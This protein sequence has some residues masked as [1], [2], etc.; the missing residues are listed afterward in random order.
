MVAIAAMIISHPKTIGLPIGMEISFSTYFLFAALL[1]AWCVVHSLL[2]SAGVSRYM[3]MRLGPLFRFYRI[4]Y[5]IFSLLS[6]IFPLLFGLYLRS[7]ETV[8]F[9]W[10]PGW[11]VIRYVLLFCASALFYFG[12][13]HYDLSLFFGIA[14]IRSGAKS[15]LLTDT[16]DFTT[17]GVAGVTRHPWYL[18]GIICIW[19]AS[20]KMYTST[21]ITACIV[22][23][24]F[25]VGTLL[26]ERKLLEKYGQA[27]GYYQQEV[28]MLLPVK[29]FWTRVGRITNRGK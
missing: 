12:A 4:V 19:S 11:G 15:T 8:L 6:L 22:S 14:Q 13:R 26:E 1:G 20:E 3:E 17:T 29:W 24:Y 21:L 23:G 7:H 25:V 16:I 2:I 5:N 10:S 9:S 18:G 27:Y 28:S